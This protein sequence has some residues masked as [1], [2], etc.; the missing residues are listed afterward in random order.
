MSR[1]KQFLI[2]ISNF[3][4]VAIVLIVFGHTFEL[5][6]TS[7]DE[8]SI[9]LKNIITGGTAFFVFISGYM[10]HHVF[11]SHYNYKSFILSKFKN[12]GV[13]YIILS[14]LAISILW[15]TDTGYFSQI[16]STVGANQPLFNVDDSELAI[17]LK[18][19]FSG[20]FLVAYWYIPFALVLFVCSPIHIKFCK[21]KLRSMIILISIFSITSLFVQRP[22]LGTNPFHSLIYYTPVYLIG[23]CVSAYKER[24]IDYIKKYFTPLTISILTITYIQTITGHNGN[25]SKNFFEYDG[26]DLMFIQK[27]ILTLVIFY[28][29]ERFPFRFSLL[30]VLSKTSFA[31][32]FIHPWLLSLVARL[33]KGFELGFVSYITL[34]T[35]IIMFSAMF[36]L[37]F[38]KIFKGSEK[39]RYLLGY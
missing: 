36:A 26:I 38:K 29:F 18:Y 3:R 31:I 1:N 16:E 11:Y 34:T 24:I 25:Y 19:Y 39:T 27:I 37:T 6:F 9:F 20:R 35:I 8:F 15:A 21:L 32:F 28:I 30:D 4:A 33:F 13:P 10:F 5:G 22:L 2:S 12:V 7:N 14:T 17:W 23:I